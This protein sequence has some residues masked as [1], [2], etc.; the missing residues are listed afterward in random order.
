MANQN[1]QKLIS[2]TFDENP[3]VRKKAAKSIS[4]L[5]DPGAMFALLE[6]SYDRDPSVKEVAQK[7]LEEKQSKKPKE[8]IPLSELFSFRFDSGDEKN[9]KTEEAKQSKKKKLLYPVE[10]LFERRLGKEKAAIVKSKMMPTLEKVY[11]KAVYNKGKSGSYDER[12]EAV[13][14]FLTTYL[15][16]ISDVSDVSAAPQTQPLEC[17]TAID[18]LEALDHV[19]SGAS[20]D[21]AKVDNILEE[22]ETHGTGISE[23]E[24]KLQDI[25]QLPNSLF[26]KAYEIMMY[27]GGDSKLMKTEMKRMIKTAEKDIKLAFQLAKQKFKENKITKLTDLKER[28]RNVVTDDLTIVSDERIEFKK[29]R[30]STFASRF[31]V[32]DP[33][34]N[35]GVLYLFNGRGDFLSKGLKIKIVKGYVKVINDET[36]MTIGSK[37]R[38]YIVV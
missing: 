4:E 7:I 18:S 31:L 14:E 36:S 30:S 38:V 25:N 9:G 32:E 11:L 21:S 10:R 17:A 33:Q 15:D 12:K 3:E 19:S 28:M 5:D 16:A 8:F 13:H 35:Q 23:E 22:V 34:G 37:G 20:L 2:L 26:K 6:L 24:Q 27:S 1:L 29:P